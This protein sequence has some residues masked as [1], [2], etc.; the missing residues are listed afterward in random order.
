MGIPKEIDIEEFMVEPERHG[1]KESKT[2]KQ[3]LTEETVYVKENGVEYKNPVRKVQ[4]ATE[5]GGWQITGRKQESGNMA[6][7]GY[8]ILP[9]L[10]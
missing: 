8:Q 4:K 1:G 5:G 6:H 9:H 10:L 7:F 3:L 2:I